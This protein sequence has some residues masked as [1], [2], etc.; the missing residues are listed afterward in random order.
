VKDSSGASF[1]TPSDGGARERLQ[2]GIERARG[3][4]DRHIT[5]K[6][7][8]GRINDSLIGPREYALR[9]TL[10]SWCRA[11]EQDVSYLLSRLSELEGE[12]AQ[13]ARLKEENEELRQE[14]WS[15]REHLIA[16]TVEGGELTTAEEVGAHLRELS[17]EALREASE[18]ESG[19][20]GER[21]P[22]E[23]REG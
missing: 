3:I 18:A 8:A 21:H 17:E 16:E 15:Y 6:S 22:T 7:L 5:P 11:Y 2:E 12:V 9:D 14:V 13:L 20:R 10:V 23:G 19:L 4:V 1:A